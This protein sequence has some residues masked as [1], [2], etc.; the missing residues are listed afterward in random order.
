MGFRWGRGDN[1]T[2]VLGPQQIF[3]RNKKKKKTTQNT[4]DSK[5]YIN[6]RYVV[7]MYKKI[8]G[9]LYTIQRIQVQHY[10][11]KLSCLL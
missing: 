8:S 6:W 9:G 10:W 7:G 4:G 1:I 2:D 5:K 3:A 11:S